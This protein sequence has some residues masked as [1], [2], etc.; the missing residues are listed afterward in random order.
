[1]EIFK[2]RYPQNN[3]GYLIDLLQK[4]LDDNTEFRVGTVSLKK[5]EILAKKTFPWQEVSLIISG[6]CRVTDTQ[7]KE[8]IM[9]ANEFIFIE[10]KEIR[11]TECLEETKIIF[12]LYRKIK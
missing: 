6:K 11:M 3:D 1:M 10:K 9:N 7:D 8:Y 2:L 12:F 5:G 4:K